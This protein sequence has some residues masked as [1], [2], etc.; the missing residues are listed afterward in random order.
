VPNEP[1]QPSLRASDADREATGERLRIA[2]TEGRLDADELEARL[3]A[4]Y[5]ARWCHQLEPLTL[6][7][8]PPPAAAPAV[9]PAFVRPERSTN[10]LAIASLVSALLW[11]WWLGS[12]AAVIMGHVALRQINRSGGRQGGRGVALAGLAI[13]YLGILTLALVMLGVALS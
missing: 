2:A 13:G 4:A 5:A 12:V 8:T 6:D 1:T 7:V 9:R 11:A 10:G 3:D